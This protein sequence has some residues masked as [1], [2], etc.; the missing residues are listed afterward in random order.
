MGRI[1]TGAAVQAGGRP[2]FYYVQGRPEVAALVPPECR[3]V[4][5]I[6][7]GR[8]RTRPA[9]QGARL[10]RRR[11]RIG[12]RGGG[13]GPAPS[14]SSRHGGRGGGAVAVP[15]GVVRR[16]DFRRRAGASDRPVARPARDGGVAGGRRLRDRQRPQRSEY[17]CDMEVI[18]RPLG[19]PRARHPRPRPPALLHPARN[20]R[21]VRS[22]PGWR[23]SKSAA[24]IGGHG[25]RETLCL[26]TARRAQAFFT[27][28]YLVVGRK[29]TA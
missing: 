24:A 7:C 27:R 21:P 13:D 17:R 14:R 12:P 2:D 6:G 29:G 4:L 16:G 1:R 23:W 11:R 25:S 9:S 22:K 8:G 19:L 10:H 26:L 15:A 28:Q 18:A 3:R 20:P 5:E